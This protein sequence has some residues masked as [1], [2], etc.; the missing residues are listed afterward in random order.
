[1][2]WFSAGSHNSGAFTPANGSLV[3]F[4][5]TSLTVT[6]GTPG[7]LPEPGTLVLASMAIAALGLARRTAAAAR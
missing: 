3:L 2:N 5:L 4:D 6:G 1:V 7:V